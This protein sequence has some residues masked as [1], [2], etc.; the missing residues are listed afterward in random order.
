MIEVLVQ[1]AAAHAGL[2]EAQTT[3]ALSGALYLIEKHGD[4]AKVSEM[5]A[6]IPGSAALAAGGA[7]LTANKGGGLMASLMTKAGG[8]GGAA[9]S[10]AMAMNQQLTRQGVTISDMQKILP[11]AMEWVRETTGR[12]LLREVLTTV[13]GLGPL[14]TSG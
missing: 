13:P 9:M 12:D 11:L 14:L 3:A 1:K 7:A 2:S 10:D 5:F 6:A 8:S 4:P